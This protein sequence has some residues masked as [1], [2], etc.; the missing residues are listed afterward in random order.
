MANEVETEQV[1]A[2]GG[3]SRLRDGHVTAFVQ[4]RGSVPGHWSQQLMKAKPPI[5]IDLPDPYARASGVLNDFI[6]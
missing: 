6:I 3:S 5:Q 4:F 1:V 2:T